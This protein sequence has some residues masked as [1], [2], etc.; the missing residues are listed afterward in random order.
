ME[1]KEFVETF[2]CRNSSADG[3]IG[4]VTVLE[5]WADPL[6]N[7]NLDLALITDYNY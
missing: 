2:I 7:S 4:Y 3:T 1:L 6:P 5:N